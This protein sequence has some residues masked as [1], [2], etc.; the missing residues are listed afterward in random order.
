[1]RGC[2]TFRPELSQ[3]IRRRDAR[4]Q[5]VRR[6]RLLCEKECTIDISIVG[7]GVL[8]HAVEES[9]LYRQEIVAEDVGRIRRQSS[10]KRCDPGIDA[11]VTMQARWRNANQGNAT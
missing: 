10:I 5:R 7:N 3:Q 11:Q 8:A 4:E 6:S 9:G 1:M 2:G